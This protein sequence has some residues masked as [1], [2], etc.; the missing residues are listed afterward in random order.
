MGGGAAGGAMAGGAAGGAT[1]GGSAGGNAGGA[2]SANLV[3]NELFVTGNANDPAI[4]PDYV[5][6]FNAG[7]AAQD[8][9]GFSLT[10]TETSDGGPKP[11]EGVVFP[12]GTS[13]AAGAFLLIVGDR[14]DA[15]VSSDCLGATAPCFGARFGLSNNGET[16]FV[17]DAQGQVF[18]SQAYPAAPAPAGSSYGRFPDGTGA[19]GTTQKTPGRANAQ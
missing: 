15:G 11:R 12:A 1:A 9:S 6:L 5:E 18:T 19:F 4:G 3:V 13:L 16:V 2:G 7:T 14:A 17:L 10:D 8:L